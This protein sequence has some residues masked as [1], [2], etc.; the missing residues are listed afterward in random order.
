MVPGGHRWPF[1]LCRHHARCFE[2]GE[3]NKHPEPFGYSSNMSI[4]IPKERFPC[5]SIPNYMKQKTIHWEVHPLLS[6]TYVQRTSDWWFRHVSPLTL[7]RLQENKNGNH[8]PHDVATSSCT[9]HGTRSKLT[10]KAFRV[11]QK[12]TSL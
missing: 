12:G 3:K 11:V 5:I 1:Y 2:R 9:G 8:Q 10:T 4:S 6:H 7:K